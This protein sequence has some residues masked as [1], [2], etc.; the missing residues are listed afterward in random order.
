MRIGKHCGASTG[1]RLLTL[2]I[3]TMSLSGCANLATDQAV[4]GATLQDRRACASALADSDIGTARV[5]CLVA[6]EKLAAGF[7]E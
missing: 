7:G 5:A 1:S 3:A 2:T 6:L 4:A